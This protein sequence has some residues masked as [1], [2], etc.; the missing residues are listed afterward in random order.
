MGKREHTIGLYCIPLHEKHCNI[1]QPNASDPPSGCVQCIPGFAGK[2]KDIICSYIC[3]KLF[4]TCRHCLQLKNENHIKHEK[5]TNKIL[6]PSIFWYFLCLS[7][8]AFSH[9]TCLLEIHW[10]PSLLDLLCVK[11]QVE[12]TSESFWQFQLHSTSKNVSKNL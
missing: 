10:H 11:A 12:A 1:L 4:V 2:V 8:H 7:C 9:P 6:F 3:W 5:T